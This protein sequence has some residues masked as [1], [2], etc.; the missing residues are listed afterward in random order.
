VLAQA[1]TVAQEISLQVAQVHREQVF[2][3]A[4]AVAV[5]DIQAQEP[6]P[7]PTM[8]ATAALAVVVGA[9]LPH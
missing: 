5:Q 4:V 2:Y 7:L 3:L 1:V 8:V 9:V 6:M